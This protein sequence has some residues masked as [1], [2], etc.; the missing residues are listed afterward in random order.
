MTPEKNIENGTPKMEPLAGFIEARYVKCGRANCH[1]TNG[2]GHGPYHYWIYKSGNRRFK[3]YIKKE[4]LAII[5]ARIEER[6]KRTR[7]FV[8]TNI[9]AKLDWKKWKTQVRELEQLFR[10][11]L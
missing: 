7:E 5:S 3:K 8:E 1:C 11:E 9:D 10:N 2:K 6:R 4:D